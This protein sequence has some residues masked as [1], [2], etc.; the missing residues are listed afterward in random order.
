MGE[1]A[2][3][4]F[5]S[6]VRADDGA[7]GGRIV[8]LAELVKNEYAMLTGREID[9]F[10]D[11]DIRWGDEWKR[12]IDEA[13]QGTAFF[14][15]VITPRFFDSE[16]CR[17]ELLTFAAHAKSLGV[18]ELVLPLLYVKVPELENEDGNDEAI[19]LVRRTQWF[20]WTDRRLDAEDSAEYRKGVH[21]L[22]SR[23]VEISRDVL[24][25]A[26]PEAT[27][28][29]QGGDGGELPLL[30]RM[31][32][33]EEAFPRWQSVI[34]RFPEV[35]QQINDVSQ[36]TA[37]EVQRSDQA[38]KGFAGRLFAARRLAGRLAQPASE[39][40]DLGTRYAQE[41]AKVDAGVLTLIRRANDEDLDE[42]ER[43]NLCE[44]FGSLR[45][46]AEITTETV[47]ALRPLLG[48]VEEMGSFS[49][50]L[51]APAKAIGDGL[52][53]IADGQAIID[54]WVRLV[55]QGSI[56]CSDGNEAAQTV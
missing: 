49:R 34:E 6:Y 36:E 9:V 14:I 11:R 27:A 43:G 2:L 32:E 44:L 22:A 31:A 5:W 42:E 54:E 8:R 35:I 10:A 17:R 29:G 13:L 41:L 47:E 37:A 55:D 18:I 24:D 38:G 39:V 4:G 25:R 15:G 7:E 21:A 48:A 23:L 52:R 26:L 1:A 16:E 53:G 51:H 50:D 3:A 20:D 28:L 40:L 30:E 46:F 56:D 19:E 12:R 45:G 33:M